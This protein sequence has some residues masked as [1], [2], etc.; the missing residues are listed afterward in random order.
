MNEKEILEE[1]ESVEVKNTQGR[2][3]MLTINNP[4]QTDEEMSEY[5]QGLEHFKY[6]AFQREKGNKE[7]TIHF[8]IFVI[9]TIG[10]RFSTIKNYFP[11]AHIEQANG[12]NAQCRD[13]CT[14]SDTRISGP[15]EIGDFAEERSRS[16][17]NGF[18][19]LVEAGASDYE[20]RKLYPSLFMKEINKLTT[21]RNVKQVDYS[22][23]ERDVEVC[24]IY[25]SSGSG[26]TTFVHKETSNEKVFKVCSFDNSAFSG[27]SGQETLIIDEFRGQFGLQFMNCLLDSFPMKLRGLGSLVNACF[28]KVYI[29]SNY[30]YSD[31]YQKEKEENVES[32]NGFCRRLHKIIRFYGKGQFSVE[33]ETIFEE[34]PNEERYQY[35]K[36][37][38][39]KRVIEYDKYGMSK[40]IFDREFEQSRQMELSEIE[41][42]DLPF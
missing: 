13:Y 24:Y 41:D 27:Y 25:G 16:D 8:Q 30:K 37:K 35:C 40:I 19:Q 2:R 15:Y 12:T 28:T 42:D 31:L 39:V 33:R 29:I 20:L 4:T 34:I 18:M 11:T 10:K 1:V 32:Y 9:F 17:I 23:Q 38:R 14:K 7:G 22:R 36:T 26:K 3:W 5:I 21:L 6:T